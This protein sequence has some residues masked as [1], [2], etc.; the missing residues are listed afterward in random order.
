MRT[1]SASFNLIASPVM[2]PMQR[3]Q[4]RI[5]SPRS[6]A[7]SIA[8]ATESLPLSGL[9]R[10]SDTAQPSQTGPSASTLPCQSSSQIDAANVLFSGDRV[11]GQVAQRC[12]DRVLLSVQIESAWTESNRARNVSPVGNVPCRWHSA[13]PLCP[14]AK[15]S[16]RT[17][18][19]EFATGEKPVL[20][21]WRSMPNTQHL[22]PEP[23]SQ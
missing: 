8:S 19:R 22:T 7:A 9:R 6:T 15:R 4:T 5:H 21:Q 14:N 23:T 18:R 10:Y 13:S 20:L 12:N 17:S 1:A 3:S 16:P 11:C 2:R